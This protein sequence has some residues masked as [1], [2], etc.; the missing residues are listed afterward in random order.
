M[1]GRFA[2]YPAMLAL[3]RG[4][5]DELQVNSSRFD[6][7]AGLPQGYL[8]KLIRPQPTRRIGYLSMGP[9]FA[10]LGIYC[11]MVEDDAATARLKTGIEPNNTQF[12]RTTKF[13][14]TRRRPISARQW[15]FIQ[16]LGR[17]ARWKKI[18]KRERRAIMRAVRMGV[19]VR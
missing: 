11:I 13:L 5:V 16:K 9:L 12:R 4:R 14:V 1:L 18:G 17:Q 7:F 19:K 15:R 6:D 10:A 3:I 8:S 2:D